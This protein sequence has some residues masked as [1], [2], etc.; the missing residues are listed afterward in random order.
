M[1]IIS[2][3][4]IRARYATLG[5][6]KRMVSTG[7]AQSEKAALNIIVERTNAG[8]RVCCGF[9]GSNINQIYAQYKVFK[10]RAKQCLIES[11]QCRMIIATT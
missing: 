10:H 7:K 4:F 6:V 3:T 9:V 5:A 2:E 1:P 11:Q 8:Q